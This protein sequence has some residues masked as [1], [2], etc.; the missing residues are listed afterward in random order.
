[1]GIDYSVLLRK[2]Y[3]IMP[4][5]NEKLFAE[6]SMAKVGCRAWVAQGLPIQGV[7]GRANPPLNHSPTRLHAAR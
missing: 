2:I 5:L 1:M 3:K 6:L 4:F 7:G